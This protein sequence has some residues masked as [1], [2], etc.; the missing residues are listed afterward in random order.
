M[1]WPPQL[2]REMFQTDLFPR[3]D[4]SC[5][6]QITPI[7]NVGNVG[8]RDNLGNF[9]LGPGVNPLAFLAILYL[10]S[11]FTRAPQV[12]VPPVYIIDGKQS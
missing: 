6:Q 9:G 7:N 8:S 3:T 12:I 1:F 4:S 2:P 11:R 10:A 5:G